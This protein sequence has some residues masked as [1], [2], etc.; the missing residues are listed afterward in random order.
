[1]K[2]GWV[3]LVIGVAVIALAACGDGKI[4][5]TVTPTVT[6]RTGTTSAGLIPDLSAL[7]FTK[8]AEERDPA[9]QAG[10]DARRALYERSAAPK[11]S[12]RV[13]IVVLADEAAAKV[14]FAAVSEALKNPPADLF[15]G[16][17][18]PKDTPPITGLGTESRS[19][20][21]SRPDAQ[22]NIVWTDAYRSGRVV[23]IVQLLMPSTEQAQPQ[24]TA[25]G[26]AILSKIN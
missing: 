17:S 8:T 19:F 13:D 23:L 20:V 25:I 26:Q 15:G 2:R 21:T 7:G 16:T 1:M 5:P 24:R 11:M 12:A 22:S 14:Q 4:T 3:S 18:T 10:Q 9:A 6:Q